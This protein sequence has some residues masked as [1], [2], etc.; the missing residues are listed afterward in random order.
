MLL[1]RGIS[2]YG[3]QVPPSGLETDSI[4]RDSQ[5]VLAGQYC[6]VDGLTRSACR[7]GQGHLET[8]AI[9]TLSSLVWTEH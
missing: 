1:S 8:S 4:R 5:L 6:L 7:L 3:R 9:H 2:A